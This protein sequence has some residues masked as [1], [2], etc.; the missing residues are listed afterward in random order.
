[1]DVNKPF[2]EEEKAEYGQLFL[3]LYA[4]SASI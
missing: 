2:A 3:E 1:M 4:I